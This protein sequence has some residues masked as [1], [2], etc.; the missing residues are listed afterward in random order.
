VSVLCH[1]EKIKEVGIITRHRPAPL[2]KGSSFSVCDSGF[3]L[4]PCG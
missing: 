3:V 1:K 4:W 2:L